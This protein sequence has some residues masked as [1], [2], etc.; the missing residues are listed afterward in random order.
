M[1]RISCSVPK[2]QSANR[3]QGKREK[4][5]LEEGEGEHVNTALVTQQHVGAAQAAAGPAEYRR[6]KSSETPEIGPVAARR[7]PPRLEKRM[8]SPG[9]TAT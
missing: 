1:R 2:K 3:H 7:L 6:E 8:P 5:G 9:R 4:D